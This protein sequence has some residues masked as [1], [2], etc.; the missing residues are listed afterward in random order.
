MELKGNDFSQSIQ[1]WNL[2]NRNIIAFYQGWLVAASN[3]NIGITLVYK[4]D[5]SKKTQSKIFW[6]M[7][8]LCII[9]MV[10]LNLTFK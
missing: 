6:I 9:G 4:F 8:P 10:I 2:V 5:V 7:C 1:T 3:L